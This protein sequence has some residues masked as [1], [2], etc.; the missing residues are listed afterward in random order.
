[1]AKEGIACG[2]TTHPYDAFLN[3]PA[4]EYWIISVLFMSGSSKAKGNNCNTRKQQY[5]AAPFFNKEHQHVVVV[6]L[7]ISTCVDFDTLNIHA[8]RLTIRVKKAEAGDVK[9]FPR[10]YIGDDHSVEELKKYR[11]QSE[12]APLRPKRTFYHTGRSH[13]LKLTALVMWIFVYFAF[14]LHWN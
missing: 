12:S 6:S 5:K 3:E 8:I 10:K 1:M 13:Y 14:T 7:W 4:G 2:S 11:M 9:Q